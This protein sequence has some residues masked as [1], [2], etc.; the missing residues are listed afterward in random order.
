M[1][2]IDQNKCN[3]CGICANVC[4]EYCIFFKDGMIII[5]YNF[6]S[7][8]A[9][10]IAVCPKEALSWN[11]IKPEKYNKKLFPDSFQIDELFKERRTVRDFKNQKIDKKLLEEIIN[12]A[13]YAPTHNF[14]MRAIIIDNE[15]LIEQIDRI[16]FKFSSRIYHLLYKP[17][18]IHRIVSLLTP[19]RE[20]E[21]LKAKPKLEAAQTRKRNFK[22]TP[23]AI[24]MIIADRRVPLSLESAQYA[25]YNIDLYA[26]AYGLGCRNLV[27]NQMFLNKSKSLRRLIGLKKHEKIFGTIA[28]GYPSLKFRNKVIGKQF[29]IQWNN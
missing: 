29:K 6:C 23:P 21:Y 9:Q 27:G 2:T 25:L 12:Y 4:H 22:T 1:I 15:N 11:N 7:T 3:T 10:C 19:E 28:I 16:I 8:C 24:I 20:H 18:I 13:A 26:Q 14:D 5:D 17:K